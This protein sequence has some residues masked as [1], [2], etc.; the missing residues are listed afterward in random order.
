VA[1]WLLVVVVLMMFFTVRDPRRDCV[2]FGPH[3]PSFVLLFRSKRP[4][5]LAFD[6][7]PGQPRNLLAIINAETFEPFITLFRETQ[8]WNHNQSLT[9]DKAEEKKSSKLHFSFV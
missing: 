4:Q 7:L 5:S 6:Q 2:K 3:S 9:P 8:N 1:G